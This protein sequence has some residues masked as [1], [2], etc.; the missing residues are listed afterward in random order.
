M[1]NASGVSA[2]TYAQG[3]YKIVGAAIAA[4]IDSPEAGKKTDSAF[5][6]FTGTYTSDPWGGEAA[7][8]P[9]QGGLAIAYFPSKEAPEELTKLKH[10]KD[11]IFQRMRKDGDL[12]E[13]IVFIQ[14]PNGNIVSM[15]EHS[16]YWPKI[17]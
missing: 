13:E 14:D 4:A 12:A 2:G 7:V 15:K 8:V 6:K 10:I 11:N 9:W 17:K 1:A 3:A 16:N 5:L